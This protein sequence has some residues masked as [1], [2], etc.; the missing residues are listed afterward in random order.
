ML[1]GYE[2]EIW[3]HETRLR[4]IIKDLNKKGPSP[5][6][7]LLIAFI[8]KS[9]DLYDNL[10]KDYV[11]L[12][13][14]QRQIAELELKEFRESMERYKSLE[15]PEFSFSDEE[16]IRKKASQED[17]HEECERIAWLSVKAYNE[18]LKEAET[19]LAKVMTKPGEVVRRGKIRKP[20]EVVK[21]EK[22]MEPVST[23]ARNVITM[24]ALNRV[25]CFKDL[26]ASSTSIAELHRYAGYTIRHLS[27]KPDDILGYYKNEIFRASACLRNNTRE[28]G[29]G[30]YTRE[31]TPSN[32]EA[33]ESGKN[34]FERR[35][36]NA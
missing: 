14:V 5:K 25:S 15:S 24:D 6:I 36:N 1:G 18:A 16:E 31:K 30:L 11:S 21:L 32:K 23:G 2:Y 20:G 26:V 3:H 34:L 19:S 17:Y 10:Y 35:E 8:R 22:I 29:L 27:R 9:L 4:A 13:S 28:Y 12:A 7:D 33:Y